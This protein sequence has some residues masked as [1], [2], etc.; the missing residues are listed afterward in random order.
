MDSTNKPNKK[1]SLSILIIVLTV[2]IALV[3]LISSDLTAIRDFVKHSGWVGLV[4][5]VLI[6]ALLGASP[7]PSEP[8]TIIIAAAIGP[9]ASTI[10]TGI[11][12]LFSALIEYY[13]GH[14]ISD[15]ANFDEQRHKLPFGLGKLPVNSPMFL[16]GARMI[17]G[18]GPKFVSLVSGMYRV[19]M[20]RYIWTTAIA[21]F[22]GAAIFA[23]GGFHLVNL[24]K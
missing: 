7:I 2:V 23:Y 3:F 16:I 4:V 15:V 18:Y 21:T 24:F 8:F 20:W 19:G 1:K 17:P 5:S 6:Y 10:V 22:S 9:I 11:G 12:N 13:M 14:K